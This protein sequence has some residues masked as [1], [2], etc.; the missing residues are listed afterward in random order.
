MLIPESTLCLEYI[1]RDLLR[2][3]VRVQQM[4]NGFGAL[5]EQMPR[6]PFLHKDI[7]NIGDQDCALLMT[8]ELNL[9]RLLI[10]SVEEN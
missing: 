8:R 1:E 7:A 10:E 4:Q 2:N 5:V 3:I 6:Q 9:T